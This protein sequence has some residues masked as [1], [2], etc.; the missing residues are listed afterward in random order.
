MHSVHCLVDDN[1]ISDSV[2]CSL[3][4]IGGHSDFCHYYVRPNLTV[5]TKQYET[6]KAQRKYRK[7]A[8]AMVTTARS[9]AT[10]ST[11]SKPDSK[12]SILH[13]L[14]CRNPKLI[15]IAEWELVMALKPMVDIRC[16]RILHRNQTNK[17][18]VHF[19]LLHE[20]ESVHFSKGAEPYSVQLCHCIFSLFPRMPN[21]EC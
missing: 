15:V 1:L 20:D 2:H 14:Q 11:A 9:E 12:E 17:H 10:Q 5:V 7:R 13:E 8:Q 18:S 6:P 4:F 16:D 3:Q 21:T 19:F